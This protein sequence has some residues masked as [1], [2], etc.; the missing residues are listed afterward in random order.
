LEELGDYL[1]EDQR[2]ELCRQIDA[3]LHQCPDCR[4]YVDTVKKTI[5]L[6]QA[7]QSVELP[8]RVSSKLA[9][10]LAHEYGRVLPAD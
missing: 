7:D 3:H 2:N 4:F 9:A 6:Y 1:D 5:V 10:A 8:V